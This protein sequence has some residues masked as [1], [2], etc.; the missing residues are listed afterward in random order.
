MESN[1]K[2]RKVGHHGETSSASKGRPPISSTSPFILQTEE[3]LKEVKL[4]QN[5]ALKDVTDHLH[6]VKQ[7]IEGIEPLEPEPVS[8]TRWT[9]TPLIFGKLTN[10]L[11]LDW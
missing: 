10:W 5:T 7:V 6:K 11:F 9:F 8:K 2:R 4:D 1:P 3:L